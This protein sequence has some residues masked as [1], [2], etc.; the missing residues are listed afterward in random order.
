MDKDVVGLILIGLF[1]GG[2]FLL[3]RRSSPTPSTAIQCCGQDNIKVI[4]D[5][6]HYHNKETRKMEYNDDGLLTLMEI[7]R[8][9]TIA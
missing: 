2:L 7:T 8:D 9:Y 3:T 5:A 4:A 6:P 1:L